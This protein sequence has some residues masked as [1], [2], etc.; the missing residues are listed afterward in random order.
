MSPWPWVAWQLGSVVDLP[1]HTPLPPLTTA[2]RVIAAHTR[3]A[4]GAVERRWPS[5]ALPCCGGASAHQGPHRVELRRPLFRNGPFQG[6]N[7]AR[8]DPIHFGHLA[9]CLFAL[10]LRDHA[11]LDL[12]SAPLGHPG[13]CPSVL[14]G[15]CFLQE[16]SFSQCRS[17]HLKGTT[18]SISSYGLPGLAKKGA[19][20]DMITCG[21]HIQLTCHRIQYTIR[22]R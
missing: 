21:S 7:C 16:V 2:L 10:S 6:T 22:R 15:A 12:A 4:S 18:F 17:L 13:F 19:Q 3:F 1:A 14:V 11:G 9:R 8:I 20:E 5:A